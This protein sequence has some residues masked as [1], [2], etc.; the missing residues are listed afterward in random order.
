[1]AII[2]GSQKC[3]IELIA[4]QAK[5]FLQSLETT[6]D[7]D[8][9]VTAAT[10]IQDRCHKIFGALKFQEDIKSE[11]LSLILTL[12]EENQKELLVEA[13]KII[14]NNFERSQDKEFR[15]K[16]NDSLASELMKNEFLASKIKHQLGNSLLAEQLITLLSKMSQK[17][18]SN[19]FSQVIDVLSS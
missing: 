4:S 14:N 6:D 3:Q 17:D 19:I 12:T 9:A 1:M 13:V 16:I 5:N 8:A 11:A 15:D 2:S 10:E 7:R 18:R